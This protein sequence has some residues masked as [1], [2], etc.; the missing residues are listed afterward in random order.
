MPIDQDAKWG[1]VP[2]LIPPR[3]RDEAIRWVK[4]LA[5]DL[6]YSKVNFGQTIARISFYVDALLDHEKKLRGFNG[7]KSL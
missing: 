6:D 7:K 1:Y 5:L 2:G 4:R 3:E